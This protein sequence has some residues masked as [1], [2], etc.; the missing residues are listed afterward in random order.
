MKPL[1][2]C[3]DARVA[4]DIGGITSFVIG[5]ASGL[6]NLKGG[7]EQYFFWTYR[8]AQQ[9]LR[10]YVSGACQILPGPLSP[11]Q[12]PW[13]S[14]L[15]SL[16]IIGKA[17]G[18]LSPLIA[19]L[20]PSPP[21][22]DGTIEAVGID[23]MHFTINHMGFLTDVPSIYHPH[24]LHHLHLSQYFSKRSTVILENFYRTFCQQAQMVAVSSSWTK[25]DLLKHYG[26]PEHKVNVIPLP[27]VLAAYPIPTED[28]LL[29]TKRKFNL[30]DQFIFYPAHTWP[31]KNHLGLLQALNIL[32]KQHNISIP[33]VSSGRHTV[34]FPTIKK[35][36]QELQLTEQTKF[37]D[38]VSPLE[39]QCLYK[40][41]RAVVIPTQFEAASF[42]LW[43]AFQAGAPTACSNV[44]SLPEQAGDAALIFDPNQPK[45]ISEAILTLWNDE[46]LRQT[47]IKR[48]KMRVGA[49]SWD[50]TARIF[51]AHYRRLALRHLTEEDRQLLAAPPLL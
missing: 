4:S 9:W 27:P 10:P 30:P 46:D 23:V 2:V 42:P 47:L 7:N 34:F 36:V 14:W 37:L 43:E 1:K 28:D 41:C 19:P 18:E 48:G 40:L 45:E 8:D 15:K 35:R 20:L 26:L 12:K 32:R 13:R 31:H 5:L 22:S 29:M 49:F 33:F 6:S 25:R 39:L 51:R 3:V 11:Q 21:K 16:P 50:R 38:F 17:W 24:D 44:T